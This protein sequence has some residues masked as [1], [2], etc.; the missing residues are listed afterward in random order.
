MKLTV[1]VKLKATQEQHAALL[2]TLR[3]CNAA[4]NRISQVAF[5]SQTLRQFDLHQATYYNIREAFA[6]PAQH[7]V[8]A[9]AKVADAYKL[10][11]DTLRIFQPTGTIELDCH[12]LRWKVQEQ[13]AAITTLQGRLPIPFACSAAQKE[14]LRGK[15]GQSDLMLRDGVFYLACSVTVEE[16]QPFVL[17]GVIGVD[18]GIVNLATDSEGNHYTGEPIRKVRRKYRRLRQ[19]LAPKK[20]ASAQTAILAPHLPDGFAGVV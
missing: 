18:L 13:I 17:T 6:L 19:L 5:Q 11:V 8:R 7:V 2:Q 15:R 4:C 12:L 14:L 9:L 3:T 16:A 20:T 10:G 1:T